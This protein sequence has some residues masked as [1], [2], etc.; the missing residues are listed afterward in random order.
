MGTPPGDD[1]L[2]Q[3][4]R[5]L[6]AFR[7]L[8]RAVET[9][10]YA[11]L[12]LSCPVLDLGCGDGHFGH[13][14]F[15]ARL[16]VGLDRCAHELGEAWGRGAHRLLTQAE[17]VRIPCPADSF[18]TVVGNSVLEHIAQ[19]QPVLE[20]IARVLRPDGW[21]CFSVPGPNFLRFLSLGRLLDRLGAARLGDA[22]RHFFN[23]VS[24][25]QHCDAS[26]VWRDSLEECGLA[27]E[28]CRVYFP[29]RALV[30]FEWLHYFGLPSLAS[31]RLFGRWVLFQSH[32]NLRL[33]EW[34]VRPVYEHAVR[35]QGA[36]AY[37]FFVARKRN[38][39]RGEGVS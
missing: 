20:E 5:E 22:Y 27:V 4:L 6:P 33:T 14:T 26:D 21:F 9:G 30:A 2:W 39:L 16:D 10:F 28:R 17:G 23:N 8:L 35:W 36:G 15:R 25:H 29:R 12:P 32:G 1:I 7:A 19:P 38:A 31:K 3:N 18:A 24:N 34:L 13:V 11:D 37:L